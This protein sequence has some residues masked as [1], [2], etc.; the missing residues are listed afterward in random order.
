MFVQRALAYL[1]SRKG[2]A[3]GGKLSHPLVNHAT[4]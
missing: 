3:E 4:V 1:E 2:E